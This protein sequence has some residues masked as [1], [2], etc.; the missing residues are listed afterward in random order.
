MFQFFHIVTQIMRAKFLVG[1]AIRKKFD[2]THPD[3]HQ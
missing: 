3:G 2:D 1:V